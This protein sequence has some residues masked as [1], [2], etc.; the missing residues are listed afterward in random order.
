MVFRGD[1]LQM[2]SGDRVRTEAV[3]KLD[4]TKRPR[5]LDANP[6]TG[7]AKGRPI[8]YLYELQGD[9]LRLCS[10]PAGQEAPATFTADANS[11]NSILTLQRVRR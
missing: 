11:P 10:R 8:F 3:F 6:V 5:R 1:K 9:N 7:A 4:A 2:V